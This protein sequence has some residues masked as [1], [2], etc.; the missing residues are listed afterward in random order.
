MS[1]ENLK[2]IFEPFFQIDSSYKRAYEGTGLGLAIC[3]GIVEQH[4]GN[5]WAKSKIKEGSTFYFTLPLT[6]KIQKLNKKEEIK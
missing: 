4:G 3:K 6:V 5:I 1:E 2:R